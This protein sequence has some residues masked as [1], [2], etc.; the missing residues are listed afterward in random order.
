M[1]L[2]IWFINKYQAYKLDLFIIISS[3][4]IIVFQ[5]VNKQVVYIT[6]F[7]QFIPFGSNKIDVILNYFKLLINNTYEPL[8]FHTHY[9][10]YPQDG[11]ETNKQNLI[12]LL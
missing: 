11:L 3:E 12:F 8:D 2:L 4:R 6:N 9:L 10:D 1:I 5:F 7:H